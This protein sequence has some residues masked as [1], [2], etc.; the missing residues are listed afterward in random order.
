MSE[1][2]RVLD[3]RHLP[4]GPQTMTASSEECAEL[5]QR[6]G[7]GQVDSMSGTVTC[8]ADGPT[9]RVTGRLAAQIVQSCAV[10]GEDF[11]V[12]I[13]E[14]VALVFVPASTAP[15]SE[16]VIELD[17]AELDEI[18]MDGMQFDLGEALAQGLALAVDPYAEGPGA[19]AARRKAG[20]MDPSD[21]GP[22]AVLK[23]LLK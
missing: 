10:S 8:T 20:V 23:K 1:F 22:F 21:V 7:L 9:V 6:F 17:A 19:E 4:A 5:A 13:D 16:E 14:P 11:S 18:E 3:A 12:R 2:S 15:A